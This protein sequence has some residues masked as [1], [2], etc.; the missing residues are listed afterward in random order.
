MHNAMTTSTHKL[1]AL[2]QGKGSH[3]TGGSYPGGVRP[4]ARHEGGPGGRADRLLDIVLLEDGR[5]GA[6]S[7]NVGRPC[8]GVVVDA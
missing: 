1:T 2:A 3:L 8:Q 4:P 6:K 5:P 7:V